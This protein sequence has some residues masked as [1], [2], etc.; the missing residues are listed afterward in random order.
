MASLER[1]TASGPTGDRVKPDTAAVTAPLSPVCRFFLA[2][3]CVYGD[4][5][6]YR[7]ESWLSRTRPDE[8]TVAEPHSDPYGVPL[9]FDTFA[10]DDVDASQTPAL[11]APIHSVSTSS[12]FTFTP[13]PDAPEFV[14]RGF[15]ASCLPGGLTAKSHR[16]VPL[17]PDPV[18]EEG[19]PPVEV[20]ARSWAQVVNPEAMAQLP[21]ADA[22]SQ[23]CPFNMIGECHYGESCAYIHGDTCDYC[24]QDVLHPWHE[25]Q[26]RKHHAICM[27]SHEEAMEVSFAVARSKDKTCGICMETVLDKNK[28]EAR[29]GILPNCTHCFCLSCLRTWRQAKQFE[30]K[31]I[32]ACPEC[33][34]T[35]DF[36]C[37]SRFWVDT[38]EDKDKLLTDYRLN[39][40]K[41]ECKYFRRG[42]GECPFGNKCFYR[43]V[44]A[45]GLAVDVGPPQTRTR[46]ANENGDIT[47]AQRVLMMDFLN[48]RDER[49]TRFLDISTE[50]GQMLRL[51]L[52]VDLEDDDDDYYVP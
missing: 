21:M 6:R 7:H 8:A 42:R 13:D 52:E 46:R 16:L 20:G 23:L 49:G 4:E 12:G 22:E 17:H 29:F 28:G 25:G 37:P 11:P 40:N 31:I 27:Q 45:S 44:D 39:L 50:F 19:H 2:G 34:Q 51:A 15:N 9:T 38:P 10:V 48:L 5:C 41:K 3:S 36:I 33:R 1:S 47:E 14:P 30:N 32:R 18:V 24:G 26:R 35:S 43:H